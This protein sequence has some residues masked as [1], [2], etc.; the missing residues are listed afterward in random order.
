MCSN[1]DSLLI[2]RNSPAVV[3]GRYQ[4]PWLE[5]D[6]RFCQANG[7]RLARRHSGGG[8]V[9]HDEG[10]INISVLTTHEGHSRKR[11]L[12]ILAHFLNAELLCRLSDDVDI[13]TSR[14][15]A[16]SRDDLLIGKPPNGGAK[17]SGTAARIARGRAYH[18]FTL[19]VDVG[20]DALRHSLNSPFKD[21]IETN[22]SR[23]VPAKS[24]GNL[25][26]HIKRSTNQLVGTEELVEKVTDCVLRAFISQYESSKL[27]RWGGE[28][29]KLRGIDEILNNLRSD[30][31]VYGKTP[32][33]T[34]QLMDNGGAICVENNGLICES[35]SGQFSIGTP[36]H[37]AFLSLSSDC[38]K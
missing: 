3:I 16:N 36:F 17:V 18:H 6:V 25:A 31:W 10:N 13:G 30:E 15:I 14:L 8:A 19:L 23:S 37:K 27:V 38:F 12:Q 22:A 29:D 2:W 34:L 5:S 32:K 24:V 4:N 7:I 20:M 1:G 9:Y 28:M 21:R 33:F 35:S 11:N 26:Q